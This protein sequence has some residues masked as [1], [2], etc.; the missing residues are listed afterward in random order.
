M[1][2]LTTAATVEAYLGMTADEGGTRLDTIVSAVSEAMQR[3]MGRTIVAAAYT[4][5]KHDGDGEHDYILPIHAPVNSITSISL[6]G[7]ALTASDYELESGVGRWP[8][9]YY[10]PGGA[11]TPSAWPAG[12]RNIV[13]AYNGGFSTVPKDLEQAAIEQ[14]AYV[15]NRKQRIGQRTKAVGGDVSE[16]YL[17]D[18]FLP[19]VLAVM[20][21]YRVPRAA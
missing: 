11:T 4:G 9:I 14:A 7:T 18:A 1:A 2:D 15:W 20:E 16:T 17:L 10:T 19:Q 12:R 3:W 5:E 8:V 6:D 21:L 13:L